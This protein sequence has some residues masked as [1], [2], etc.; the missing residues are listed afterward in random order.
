VGSND[1]PKE[2][3]GEVHDLVA[4]ALIAGNSDNSAVFQSEAGFT[5][6][7]PAHYR[8]DQDES[9][10]TKFYIYL[11]DSTSVDA[12]TVSTDDSFT[13]HATLDTVTQKYADAIT[14]AYKDLKV[15]SKDHTTLGGHPAFRAVY[16]G[17]LPVQYA[18][19]T[20]RTET[21]KVNQTWT[22]KNARV[23]TLTYKALAGDYN[24]YFPHARQIM[25]SFT[26][27]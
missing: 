14:S 2:G 24:R 22:I 15:L 27:R 25:K 7:Y 10:A 1:A 9:T 5:I 4:F 23:Y 16:R 18:D 6:T 19:D 20:I 13:E 3:F 26:L 12:V 8:T 11:A 17:V 21:L